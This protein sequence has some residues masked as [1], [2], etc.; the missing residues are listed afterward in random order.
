[1]GITYLVV[2][3]GYTRPSSTAAVAGRV[4]Q[5]KPSL[6]YRAVLQRDSGVDLCA[7]AIIVPSS[8]WLTNKQGYPVLSKRYQKVCK[9]YLNRKASLNPPGLRTV[10]LCG[11][12]LA[13][14]GLWFE[15][16]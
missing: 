6:P 10:N 14:V 8:V 4:G 5:G 3:T 12:F 9:M 2:L 15:N 13:R 16:E 1:M 11:H 7:K